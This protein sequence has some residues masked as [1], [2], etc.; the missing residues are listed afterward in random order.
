MSL[1][2]PDVSEFQAPGSGNAP[3]WA[4]I[5]A[6]NGG[7]AIIRVGYGNDHLDRMF[8]SNY[9]ALK[10]NGFKVKGLYQYLRAGQDVPSQANAFI[11]WIG[12]PSAVADGTMF[13]LDLEEGTGDQSTRAN[14]WF[15][16]VDAFYGLDIQPLSVRSWL[17]SG[18][19]FAIDHGLAPI[20]RSARRTWVAAYG[21]VEPALPHSL[22][23]STDGQ[24]QFPTN[25]TN[26]AGCGFCDTSVYHG[27][28][29]ELASLGW[30]AD[31]APPDT[32]PPATQI[33]LEENVLH[34]DE[35]T[36]VIS[37]ANS[38]Y[39]W[40]AFFADPAVTGLPDPQH[41]RVA[42]WS[43]D[44]GGTF[45]GI[46]QD[47]AVGTATEKVTVNLPAHC[48]GVSIQRTGPQAADPSTWAPIAWNLG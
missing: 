12:P 20:F 18:N 17:Y 11:N 26:W 5:K 43:A 45:T 46:V 34:A 41:I 40:I 48:A 16:I 24:A 4:G 23:Q 3:N 33:P 47:V 28:I 32:P 35:K 19:N 37:F 15:S 1:V 22:W 36:T 21:S 31:P 29:D 9:T 38:Q 13:M 25:R 39:N 44:N 7:A 42:P 27:T 30:H 6:Q 8:V 2:L 10:A 14:Q